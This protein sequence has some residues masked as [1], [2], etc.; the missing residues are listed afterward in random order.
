MEGDEVDTYRM[1][2]TT[3]LKSSPN[4]S[5]IWAKDIPKG[6]GKGAP[7]DKECLLLW[8]H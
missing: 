6:E 2:V 4:P 1:E 7:T 8:V 5:V 3:G